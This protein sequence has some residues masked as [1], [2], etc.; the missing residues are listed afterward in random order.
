MLD[1]QR[2]DLV[3]GVAGSGTMGRGIVQVL[4]QCGVRALVFDAKP[5]AAQAAQD[6]IGKSLAGLVQKGRV[7]QADA[8]K[9]LARIEIVDS[10]AAFKPCHVVIEAI[11][12]L[13]APKQELFK[14]LEAVVSDSCI[15]ASNTSSLSVTAMA[16]ACSRPGR[17]A[18][19][20]FFNPVPVMKI[21]EVVEGELTEPWV[22]DALSA[23]ARRYGHKPVRC[24]DTPG[25]IINHAGRGYVPESLRVLQEGVAD[26]AT[27][28]RI[29]VDAAGFRLGPF[30]LLDLVGLDVAHG[31]MKSMHAQYFQEPKY[32]PS[33]LSDPRVA[34]GLLGR[35]TGRGWYRYGKDGVA[36]KIPEQ[37]T[38]SGSS[39]LVWCVPELKDLLTR[40]GAKIE[41]KPTP[42]CICFVAPL[43]QDATGT[44]LQLALDPSRT[45]A[46]DPLFGFGKRRTLM[47][48]P[49]TRPEVRDAAHALLACDGVPVS[50]I[51]DSA[52]FVAQRVV[53]HIVN[54]GCDIV[55]QRIATPED[56]DSAVVLGLNYPRGP[57]AM[58]DAVGA[59]K[60]LAVLEAMHAFYQEPR[61]RPSPWLKRRAKLGISLLTPE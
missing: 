7:S 38:P 17:V 57:L 1:I 37:K 32:Q 4:A 55:Q 3:A 14:A 52:G 50:V 48:T 35:K 26:F 9:T 51:R 29:L 5:G 46:I 53:G 20:H 40:L 58:G 39:G 54:V 25:F 24:K 36:E 61:Y 34:A 10:L 28:D 45:V 43:G 21:V 30:G 59:P 27:I 47:T 11:V 22:G 6:A 8:D 18:G 42:D 49:V 15:L 2:P 12:E 60:I 23:L 31:V 41:P 19:Y 33:Y 13:L 56:L 44:A 16:A